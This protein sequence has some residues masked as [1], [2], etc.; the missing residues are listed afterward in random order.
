MTYYVA[1][2]NCLSNRKEGIKQSELLEL[3]DNAFDESRLNYVLLKD[4]NNYFV[5]PKGAKELDDALVSQPLEWLNEYPQAKKEWVE[6]LRAYSDATDESASD[7]ADKFR[8]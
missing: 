7:V 5:F 3:L 2:I 8:K 1:F 6:A 4:N